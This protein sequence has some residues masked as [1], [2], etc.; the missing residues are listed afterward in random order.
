MVLWGQ[1]RLPGI[2]FSACNLESDR[3][4]IR[5]L[6]FPGLSFGRQASDDDTCSSNR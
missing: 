4:T 6:A 5:R 2:W 3:S 1:V